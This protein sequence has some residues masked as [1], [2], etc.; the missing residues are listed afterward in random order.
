[1]VFLLTLTKK[2]C[3]CNHMVKWKQTVVILFF[4]KLFLKQN[5]NNA[6]VPKLT[7]TCIPATIINPVI[8]YMYACY[9]L[10]CALL[11]CFLVITLH[12]FAVDPQTQHLTGDFVFLGHGVPLD[13]QLRLDRQREV[14]GLAVRGL[15]LRMSRRALARVRFLAVLFGFCLGRVR[16][17]RLR[18]SILK[19]L[20]AKWKLLNE[21]RN[22]ALKSFVNYPVPSCCQ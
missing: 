3:Y 9:Y 5:H 13:F 17:V 4:L 20:P 10:Q 7:T 18:H 21:R 6:E 15:V 2:Y 1:M 12:Y 11:C 16:A 19:H 8:I 22:V 14:S